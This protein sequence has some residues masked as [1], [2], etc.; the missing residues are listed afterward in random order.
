MTEK[1]THALSAF[2]PNGEV[3]AQSWDG[4]KK[5][6]ITPA[7]K[8]YSQAKRVPRTF[9]RRIMAVTNVMTPS[10]AR[11]I[12]TPFSVLHEADI[13]AGWGPFED[14]AAL[15]DKSLDGVICP[16]LVSPE[17]LAELKRVGRSVLLDLDAPLIWSEESK[18]LLLDT[19]GEYD[20]VTVPNAT[21]AS[22]LRAYHDRVFVTQHTLQSA[23]WKDT[24]FEQHQPMV[25]G[26][27]MDLD[28]VLGESLEMIKTYYGDRVEIEHYDWFN[29]F[30]GDE[31][32]LYPDLD[33]ICLG[34]PHES[35]QFSYAPILPAMA[36]YCVVMADLHWPGVKHMQTGIQIGRH[37]V[38]MWTQ[39]LR[40]VIDDRRLRARISRNARS[41]ASRASADRM[42]NHLVLPYRL[43][44]PEGEKVTVS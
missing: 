29:Q 6:K 36:G 28:N 16:G 35:T 25:I 10:T 24:V 21:F 33:V 13:S 40:S 7:G 17:E 4:G 23:V 14:I 22:R 27:P 5:W 20:G 38:K 34:P 18:N 9:T 32:L 15:P 31:A 30:P 8:T 11:R 39:Y 3:L 43:L 41:F 42:V 19:I 2:G 1:V 44:I 37:N 12:Q 26:V